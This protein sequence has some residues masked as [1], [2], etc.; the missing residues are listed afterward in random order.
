MDYITK[1]QTWQDALRL[2]IYDHYENE[3]DVADHHKSQRDIDESKG[4]AEV[5]L[6]GLI[7]D[8]A[9]FLLT[10]QEHPVF[11]DHDSSQ[12]VIDRAV[13]ELRDGGL[14][15]RTPGMMVESMRGNRQVGD[16]RPVKGVA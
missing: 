14:Q 7:K 6:I 9:P 2:K 4:A 11:A 13:R 1:P 3:A 12:G 8:V 5:Q 16:A 15:V 10:I